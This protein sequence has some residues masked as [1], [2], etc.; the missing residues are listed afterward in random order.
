MTSDTRMD[1]AILP[2][3]PFSDV[4]V[5]DVDSELEDAPGVTAKPREIVVPARYTGPVPILEPLPHLTVWSPQSSVSSSSTTFSPT[6]LS[7][8][9]LILWN[10]A[11]LSTSLRRLHIVKLTP[12]QCTS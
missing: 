9:G 2:E 12:P 3:N 1:S 5:V 10:N 8:T 6:E 4:Y 7:F 11:D